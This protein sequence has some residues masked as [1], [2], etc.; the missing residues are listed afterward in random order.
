MM[1]GA[2]ALVLRHVSQCTTFT[3]GLTGPVFMLAVWCTRLTSL[4]FRRSLTVHCRFL[5][6]LQCVTL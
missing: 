5:C 6:A 1:L 2:R 4:S 3:S